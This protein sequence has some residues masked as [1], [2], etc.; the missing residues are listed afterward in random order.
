MQTASVIRRDLGMA[1]VPMVRD[2][3]LYQTES[4]QTIS[5]RSRLCKRHN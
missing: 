1:K 5:D 4:V 3:F 2:A